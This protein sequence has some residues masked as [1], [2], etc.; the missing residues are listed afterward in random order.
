MTFCSTCRVKIEGVNKEDP[1]KCQNP[2]TGILMNRT[3]YCLGCYQKFDT[4]VW[5]R[6]ALRLNDFYTVKINEIG[7]KN[8]HE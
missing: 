5:I 4:L 6:D 2:V 1:D 3:V 8:T 7:V